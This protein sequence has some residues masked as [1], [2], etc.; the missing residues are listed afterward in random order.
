MLRHQRFQEHSEITRYFLKKGAKYDN[1]GVHIGIVCS[2]SLIYCLFPFFL[3]VS[4]NFHCSWSHWCRSTSFHM[5]L[6]YNWRIFLNL[7]RFRGQTRCIGRCYNY[8]HRDN[9][10]H[11]WFNGCYSNSRCCLCKGKELK[12]ACSQKVFYFGSNLQKKVQNHDLEHL[13]KYF[14]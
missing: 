12:V 1:F 13:L 2:F 3:Q 14:S 8:R 11:L 10:L 6:G 7:W 5:G 9:G 4:G